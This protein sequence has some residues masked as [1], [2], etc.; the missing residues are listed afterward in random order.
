MSA[1]RE[2]PILFSD[3][4]VRAILARTKTQTRRVLT[5]QPIEDSGE[6]ISVGRYHPTTV[7]RGLEEPGDER[8]GASTSE[9]SWPC[10]CSQD[11]FAMR[12]GIE[13]AALLLDASAQAQGTKASAA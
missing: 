4:M 3:A 8:F 7:R 13:L 11:S 9:Q 1:Q 5:P 12:R 10:P 2:R 6:P